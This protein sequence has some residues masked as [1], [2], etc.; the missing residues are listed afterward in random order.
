MLGQLGSIF[1]RTGEPK[2]LSPDCPFFTSKWTCPL[3]RKALCMKGREMVKKRII[4]VLICF[5]CFT[6]LYGCDKAAVKDAKQY[7]ISGETAYEKQQ[8]GA[9]IIDV[10]DKEEYDEKHISGSISIEA[11]DIKEK[12]EEL[13]KDHGQELIFYCKKGGRS[14]GALEQALESGYVNVYRLGGIDEWKNGFEGNF[15]SK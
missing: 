10:R 13:Y 3:T 15:D 2:L 6:M 12:L 4:A 11:D 9:V 8:Q 1:R 7:R 5:I 14:Q